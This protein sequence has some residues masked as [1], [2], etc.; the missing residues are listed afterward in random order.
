MTHLIR[1][2]IRVRVRSKLICLKF[3]CTTCTL[4]KGTSTTF[5]TLQSSTVVG[6]TQTSGTMARG[7]NNTKAQKDGKHRKETKEEKAL[8]LKTQQEAR[9]VSDCHPFL[10]FK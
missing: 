10:V 4:P 5:G 6:E 7:K 2:I 8:R 3:T 9:E 1:I